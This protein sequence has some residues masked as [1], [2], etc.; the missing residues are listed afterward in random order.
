MARA[1]STITSRGISGNFLLLVRESDAVVLP[2]VAVVL[3]APVDTVVP[4][5]VVAAAVSPSSVAWI[6]PPLLA[7]GPFPVVPP[8]S[9]WAPASGPAS[10]SEWAPAS[11]SPWG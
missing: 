10:G 5:P 11:G 6:T 1:A 3:A 9:E 2:L 4:V 8:G 7:S